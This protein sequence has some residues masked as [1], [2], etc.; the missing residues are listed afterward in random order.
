MATELSAYA[1]LRDIEARSRNKALGL[2]Q[3]VEM[4]RTWSGV[5]FRLGE[6]TLLAPMKDVEEILEI[7]DMTRIP[8]TRSWVK[9]IANIRGSLLPIMDLH[10]FIDGGAVQ[11]GR[12]SRVLLIRQGELASGLLVDEV[13]GMRHFFEEEHTKQIPEVSLNLQKY[14]LGAYRQGNAHWGVFSMKNLAEDPKFL[15]VA[16]NG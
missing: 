7:P 13:M 4:R 16:A 12:K 10:G 3:Q 1:L 8:S 5:A 6:T 9:G 15:Q 14:L 11:I 2:P